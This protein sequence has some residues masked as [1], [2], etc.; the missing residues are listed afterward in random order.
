MKKS[1]FL[2]F[3]LFAVLAT[4]VTFTSCKDYDDDIEK[5]E[6]GLASLKTTVDAMQQKIES[7]AVI[8]G[9]ETTTNGITIKLSDGKSYALTNGTVGKDGSVVTI[10]ANG[11]WFIDGKDTGKESKGAKGSDGKDGVDGKDGIYYTPGEDGFWHMVEGETTTITTGSWLIEGTITAKWEDGYVILYNVEGAEGPISIGLVG[12]NNL[13]LIPDHVSEDGTSVLNFATLISIGDSKI[14]QATARYQVSPT[15]ASE[16][17]IDKDNLYF[18]TNNPEVL[19][20]A[21]DLSPKAEFIS[22]EDGIL[23]VTASID[24]D[25]LEELEVNGDKIIQLMLVVPSTSGNEVV[26]DFVKVV[27]VDVVEFVP[28][29]TVSPESFKDLSDKGEGVTFTIDSN[30]EAWEVSALPDWLIEKGK[31]ATSLT[32]TVAPN[33]EEAR[34]ASVTFNLVT[35]PTVT[36]VVEISQVAFIPPVL[37]VPASEEGLSVMLEGGNVKIAVQSNVDWTYT[38]EEGSWLSEVSKTTTELELKAVA[39][40]GATRVATVTITSEST[41]ALTAKVVITQLSNILL[42]ENFDWLTYGDVIPYVTTG[43]KRFDT[44]TEDEKNRGWEVT[45][46]PGSTDQQLVYARTGFIKLGKTG[47]GSDIISPKLN[48]VNGPVDI[49]V[50]FKAAAYISAGGAIDDTVL[51]VFALGAGTTSVS[52]FDIDNI[53]NNKAQDEAEVVNN[54]W[55]P[56]RAYSFYITGVTSE[57]Q[58]RFLGGAMDL[59]GIGQGKN[60]I[61]LDDI[62]VEIVTD[63]SGSGEAPSLPPIIW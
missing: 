37:E 29:L 36:K 30:N 16:K 18:K 27:S 62:K 23:T 63:G 40:N 32:L 31:T 8:T 48:V 11:N 45:P 51:K 61:F 3:F 1:L 28:V 22:L 60:R 41:P 43:E 38:I 46:N 34:T 20:R 56:A 5:L 17:L 55:D 10:G 35:Y 57:T 19:T 59:K 9:V 33:L 50:T 7:G 15:N 54:I 47:F 42:E 52:E 13:I 58:I 26:S 4:F 39:N 14:L 53:P 49:K 12:L 21:A 44:W 2:K 25:A 24:A 6:T